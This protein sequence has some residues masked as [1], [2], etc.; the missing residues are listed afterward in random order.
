MLKEYDALLNVQELR[1]IL[2]IGRN[3]AYD[4]LKQGE[5]QAFRI[6]RNWK[7]PKDSVIHYIS[8][9]QNRSH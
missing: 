2:S 3:S 8:Q 7:I 4:L 6:G 1:E 5:I 9:W